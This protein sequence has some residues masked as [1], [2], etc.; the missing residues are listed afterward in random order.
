MSTD[1][2]K[3]HSTVEELLSYILHLPSPKDTNAQRRERTL[4]KRLR[5]RGGK[6]GQRGTNSLG[7]GRE[8]KKKSL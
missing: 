3:V 2:V 5:W 8:S 6:E 4:A 1:E 7:R